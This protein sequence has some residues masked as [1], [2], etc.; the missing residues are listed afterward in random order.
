MPAFSNRLSS[1]RMAF[2]DSPNSDSS[3]RR[4]ALVFA[5]KKNFSKSLILV[6]EEISVSIIK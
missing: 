6:F 5:L 4:Y 3:A 2:E 1:K